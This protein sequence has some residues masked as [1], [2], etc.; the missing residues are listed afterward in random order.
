MEKSNYLAGL[1]KVDHDFPGIH[2][3]R[4]KIEFH[5][6]FPFGVSGD[7][8]LSRRKGDRPMDDC[9]HV[10][11]YEYWGIIKPRD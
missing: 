7:K 4:L 11:N 5:K 2:K 9:K 1:L 8:S 3:G 10:G 6:S